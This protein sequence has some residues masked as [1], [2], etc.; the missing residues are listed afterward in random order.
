MSDH[1]EKFSPDTIRWL[2]QRLQPGNWF[3]IADPDEIPKDILGPMRSVLHMFQLVFAPEIRRR[4]SSGEIDD[5]FVLFSAQLIQRMDEPRV[6]RINEEVR[7][8]GTI[9][10]D[11]PVQPGEMLLFSDL[12]RMQHFDL[13]EDELDAGHFTLF[14]NGS[15]WGCHFDFRMGRAKAANLLDAASEFLDSAKYAQEQ[16]FARACVDNLFSACE[17]AS[18]ARL[19]LHVSQI[20]TTDT[21]KLIHNNINKLRQLGVVDDAFVSLFNVLSK[22]RKVARYRAYSQIEIPTISDLQLAEREIQLLRQTVG[23]RTTIVESGEDKTT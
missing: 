5:K 23:P 12:K 10:M 7:G 22:E 11:R 3:D 18:K 6:V 8:V 13:E 2:R 14:W 21:H 16:G 20:E 9:K 4:L 1:T 19:I 17:L 15:T